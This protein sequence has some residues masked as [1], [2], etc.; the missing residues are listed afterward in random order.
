MAP[1]PRPR[2]RSPP[3]LRGAPRA[4]GAPRA[5]RAR[6]LCLPKLRER[7]PAYPRRRPAR[8]ACATRVRC[9][10]AR[11]LPPVPAQ[12]S[13]VM[14]R[15]LLRIG[16]SA[17]SRPGVPAPPFLPGAALRS[18]IAA[19]CARGAAAGWLRRSA[20][21]PRPAS[22]CSAGPLRAGSL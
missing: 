1:T 3:G 20:L 10:R 18:W 22:R 13:R 2:P 9:A 11:G 14:R 12:L 7:D 19:S 15:Q 4:Q 17:P 21:P 8:L 6:G 5:V 16:E